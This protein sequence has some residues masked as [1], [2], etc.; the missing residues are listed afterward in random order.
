MFKTNSLLA[1]TCTKIWKRRPPCLQKY[2]LR[3]MIVLL[4][5]TPESCFFFF[6]FYIALHDSHPYFMRE[7]YYCMHAVHQNIM[8]LTVK[9]IIQFTRITLQNKFVDFQSITFNI[10]IIS[11]CKNC[12][13]KVLYI[14]YPLYQLKLNTIIVLY[15]LQIL[16]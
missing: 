3:L 6:L 5:G 15:Q 16:F 11:S 8:Y 1:F 14:V 10:C 13:E 12:P 2:G 7:N 9:E 4:Q